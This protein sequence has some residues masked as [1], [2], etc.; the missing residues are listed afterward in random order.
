LFDAE[1]KLS[2]GPA[3]LLVVYPLLAFIGQFP[4]TGAGIPLSV[5]HIVAAVCAVVMLVECAFGSVRLRSANGVFLVGFVVWSG[6]NALSLL[7]HPSREGNFEVF[8]YIQKFVFCYLVFLALAEARCVLKV[9][10]WYIAGCFIAGVFTI[11]FFLFQGA[12]LDDLRGASYGGLDEAGQLQVSLMEGLARSGAGNLL[13]FWFALVF[14]MMYP[15]RGRRSL[16]LGLAAFFLLL[17]LMA[18]RREVLVCL[19]FGF[20]VLAAWA[21]REYRGPI[22]LVMGLCLCGAASVVVSNESWSRRLFEET[23]ED[24][25]AGQDP[26]LAMLVATPAALLD[27]PLLGHGPGTY[28]TTILNYVSVRGVLGETGL[29]AHNSFSAAAVQAGCVGLLGAVL[30][31]GGLCIQVV[32]RRQYPTRSLG[33]I[34]LASLIILL[35]VLDRQSFGDGLWAPQ[36]WFWFGVLLAQGK[37]LEEYSLAQEVALIPDRERG[38][39]RGGRPNDRPDGATSGAVAV[40][41]GEPGV[42]PPGTALTSAKGDGE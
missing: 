32:G 23:A 39:G 35:E 36:T 42:A 40:R 20:V 3:I 14:F 10:R 12:S 19:V 2:L 22:A 1:E 28:R 13:P 17:S 25:S 16:Y 11:C 30:M 37:I 26:R 27:K 38:R 4:I 31:T 5:E 29:A 8:G 34:R 6:A 15:D 7:Q 18:L 41:T 21:P 24:L 9:M 33:L